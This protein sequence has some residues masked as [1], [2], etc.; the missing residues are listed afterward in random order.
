MC[1]QIHFTFLRNSV[2]KLP[3]W[4]GDIMTMVCVVFPQIEDDAAPVYA[5]FMSM[6]FVAQLIKFW[7]VVWILPPRCH[8]QGRIAGFS[9]HFPELPKRDNMASIHSDYN[10]CPNNVVHKK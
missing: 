4:R 7:V 3:S 6:Y 10:T 9:R 2:L 5:D 8:K 1:S